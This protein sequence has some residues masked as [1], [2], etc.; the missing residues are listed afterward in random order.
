M[1]ECRR[2]IMN[3][4]RTFSEEIFYGAKQI[5]DFKAN[6]GLILTYCHKLF[7]RVVVRL[8]KGKRE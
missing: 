5:Y 1:I 2:K 7:P 4:F 3:G 6:F 8:S